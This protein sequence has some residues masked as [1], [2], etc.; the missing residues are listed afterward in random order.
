MSDRCPL[1]Y[2]CWFSHALA[3]ILTETTIVNI[4]ILALKNVLEKRIRHFS[5]G[6]KRWYL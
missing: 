3:E 1:G 5:F 4:F 2:L 6:Y